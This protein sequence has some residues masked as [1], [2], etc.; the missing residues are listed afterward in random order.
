M[1]KETRE[2]R[3]ISEA[4]LDELLAGQD[5]AQVFRDGSLIDDLKKAVA[6]RALDAEMDAH[7]EGERDAENRRNGH[8]RKR[9]LTDD[10]ALDLEVPRDRAGRF[11]PQL[12]EKYAR[13][14]P[15]FDDKVISMYARGMTTRE[16]RGHVAEIY[17]V[18]VSAELISKV[19]DAVLE[20]V[21]E[22]QARPLEEVYVIVYFDAVRVKACSCGTGPRRGS[23][24]QQG[25]LSGD[26][27]DL[28]GAQGSAGS[29]DRADGGGEVLAERDERPQGTWRGGR[30][31]RRG[32][33]SE[34]LSGRHRGGVPAGHGAD[35]HRASDPA[36]IGVCVVQGAAV[37]GGGA[38]D[39]LPGA[40]RGRGGS[41][42]G[43][44]RG[45]PVGREVPGHR[46]EL[47]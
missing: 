29:V 11:E 9:V 40:D 41:G 21:A 12:V 7:L 28:C 5:P 17:G 36:L 34:G 46:E 47:A 27:R 4:L 13:R 15:G 10:S 39:H 22:W 14:L 33:R 24:T 32:R 19:A 35:L 44:P 37:A 16:I 8:N 25:R 31:D 26:W 38:E 23:G 45:R 42:A 18:R 43:R 20:E 1:A 6:E 2:G 3:R 30:P